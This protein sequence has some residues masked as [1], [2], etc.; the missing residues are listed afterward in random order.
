MSAFDPETH[1]SASLEQWEGAAPGWARWQ[2]LMRE[3]AG[4]VS[5]ALLD[6][7]GL[8]PGMAVLDIAAGV[9]DTG[10]IAAQR[11]QPD[12]KAILGDQAEAM[13]RAAALR[14]QELGL[15]NV[16]ARQLNAEWLD[17]PT[18]SLDA[19]LCRWGIM[20]MADPEAALRELRRVLRPGGRLALADMV[21]DED[22]QLAA[23]QN[24]LERMRDPSH[25]GMLSISWIAGTIEGLGLGQ[26]AVQSRTIERPV[27]PWLTQSATSAEVA[28]AIRQELRDELAGGPQTGLAPHEQDGELRFRQT[29]ACVQGVKP[30]RS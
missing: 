21:A 2:G 16:E 14:A 3:F 1:R 25:A 5:E 22:E 11:V 15:H 13:V 27:E 24:R 4:P 26:I 6:A 8:Q 29:W 19:A 23:A 10:L 18:A 7:L 12:G 28:D 30:A 20:L 9:G 17:L